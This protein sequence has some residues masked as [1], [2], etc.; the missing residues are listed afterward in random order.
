MPIEDLTVDFTRCRTIGHAWF[1]ADSSEWKTD[2]GVPITLRCERCMTER[3]E[4]WT[5]T[6]VLLFRT[7]VYPQGYQQ[8]WGG[9]FPTKDEFRRALLAIRE[10]GRRTRT[11]AARKAG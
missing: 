3:R 11:S 4:A 8:P 2:A 5:R 10:R 6:G 9:N 1:E 7:Y